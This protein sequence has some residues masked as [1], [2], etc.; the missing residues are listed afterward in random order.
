MD[1]NVGDMVEIPRR[2]W[3]YV[4]LP[5]QEKYI[6]NHM[7]GAAIGRVSKIFHKSIGADGLIRGTL[8]VCF[9][10]EFPGY[11]VVAFFGQVT[12]CPTGPECDL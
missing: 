8:E 4:F 5:D 12:T 10:D 2:M 9:G 6:K 3:V 11:N 7:H 1:R